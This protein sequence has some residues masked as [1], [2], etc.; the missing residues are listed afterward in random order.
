MIKREFGSTTPI[1]IIEMKNRFRNKT[2]VLCLD[3]EASAAVAGYSGVDASKLFIGTSKTK[4]HLEEQRGTVFI[5]DLSD[6]PEKPVNGA[7]VGVPGKVPDG[8]ISYYFGK[9]YIADKT[10]AFNIVQ[11][12]ENISTIYLAKYLGCNRLVIYGPHSELQQDNVYE[13]YMLNCI[14]LD[15]AIFRT[16]GNNEVELVQGVDATMIVIDGVNASCGS[17]F[18]M[19]LSQQTVLPKQVLSIQNGTWEDLYVVA[20]GADYEKI[21]IT[22]TGDFYSPSYVERMVSFLTGYDVVGSGYSAIYHVPSKSYRYNQ[23]AKISPIQAISLHKREL[24]I[25]K[26]VDSWYLPPD[27]FEGH[28]ILLGSMVGK[29]QYYVTLTGMG[30]FSDNGFVRDSFALDD[31]NMSQF[32]KWL[33]PTSE[34]AYHILELGS[35]QWIK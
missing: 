5:I 1:D 7:I 31:E 20:G 4:Q 8:F 11:K 32:K 22:R 26:K 24:D 2:A 19:L 14:G 12:D 3:G 15:S 33:G 35:E 18:L 10:R 28:R 29:E 17:L 34:D 13:K 16:F 9:D 21:L 27:I 6:Q 30:N 23:R 25:I